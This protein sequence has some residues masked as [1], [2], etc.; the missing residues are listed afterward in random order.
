MGARPEG[1]YLALR[2]IQVSNPMGF[3]DVT[4]LAVYRA[5]KHHFPD[6]PPHKMLEQFRKIDVVQVER[7]AKWISAGKITP[8][9]AKQPAAIAV[10]LVDLLTTGRIF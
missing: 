7:R 5:I 4:F 10:L 3:K 1:T 6:V 2:C 9:M 8:T